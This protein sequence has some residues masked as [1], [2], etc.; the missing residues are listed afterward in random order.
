MEKYDFQTVAGMRKA[1]AE[2]K[3]IEQWEEE[4][5]NNELFELT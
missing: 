1:F 5:R 2:I 4:E 3:T